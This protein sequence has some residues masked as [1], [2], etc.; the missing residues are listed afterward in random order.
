MTSVDAER[1]RKLGV[2]G[3][4]VQLGGGHVEPKRMP[5]SASPIWLSV[6]TSGFACET[7]VA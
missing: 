4:G 2:Q 7:G 3:C 1:G 6:K 5:L